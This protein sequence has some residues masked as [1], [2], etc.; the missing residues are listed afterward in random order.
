[1]LWYSHN[2]KANSSLPDPAGQF[3]WL[4]STL[5]QA[6]ESNSKVLLICH[7]PPG[8]T[9]NSPTKYRHFF[10]NYNQRFIRLLRENTDIL[11]GGLFAHQHTDTF[12]VLK[13]EE[14]PALPLLFGPSISPWRLG[15]L[16][17][18]NPRV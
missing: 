2:R 11:I 1:M 6:R 7:F 17:A 5:S 3:A 13:E 9:E 14:E 16:G 12:R 15:G 8:A 4:K 18:F 10:D